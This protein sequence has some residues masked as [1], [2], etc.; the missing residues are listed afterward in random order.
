MQWRVELIFF[1]IP[2]LSPLCLLVLCGSAVLLAAA[3]YFVRACLLRRQ[4]HQKKDEIEHAILKQLPMPTLEELEGELPDADPFA[5]GADNTEGMVIRERLDFLEVLGKRRKKWKDVRLINFDRNEILEEDK[6]NSRVGGF[7]LGGKFSKYEQSSEKIGEIAAVRRDRNKAKAEDMM[8]GGL[9]D[10][11][12]ALNEFH[13]THAD[14]LILAGTRLPHSRTKPL[15][16]F[17]TTY[18]LDDNLQDQQVMLWLISDHSQ[19]AQVLRCS[20]LN[21]HLHQGLRLP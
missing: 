14:A 8:K 17:D 5:D 6:I 2:F 21:H 13:A 4:K 1:L 16:I 10:L 7:L 3:G 20:L 9:I 19:G 12:P 11:S 18:Q 15:H